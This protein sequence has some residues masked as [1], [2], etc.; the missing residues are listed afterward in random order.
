MLPW[1]RAAAPG[2]K[3]LHRNYGREEGVKQR[4]MKIRLIGGGVYVEP[5]SKWTE[6]LDGDLDNA[7]VGVRWELE[8]VEMTP[9]EYEGLSEFAGH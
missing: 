9:E 6:A 5:L 2:A 7:E 4:Y 1:N 3:Q 8:L